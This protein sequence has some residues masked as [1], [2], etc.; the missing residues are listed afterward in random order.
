MVEKQRDQR[1]KNWSVVLVSQKKEEQYFHGGI[2][3][4]NDEEP[5]KKK[6]KIH[7]DP[8]STNGIHNIT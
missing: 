4:L 5:K 3:E 1:G 8:W 6:K 7:C 2:N